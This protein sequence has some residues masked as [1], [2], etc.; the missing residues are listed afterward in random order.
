LSDFD[1]G[2]S[3]F[4]YLYVGQSSVFPTPNGTING[5][6]VSNVNNCYGYHQLTVPSGSDETYQ[7][8]SFRWFSLSAPGGNVS[9]AHC[10]PQRIDAHDVIARVVVQGNNSVR[11]NLITTGIVEITTQYVAI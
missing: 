4:A 9:D 8:G 11:V 6:F 1:A 3:N 2:Q 7:Y 5:N 10:L